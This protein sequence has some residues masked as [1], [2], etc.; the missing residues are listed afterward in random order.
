MVCQPAAANAGPNGMMRSLGIKPVRT[1]VTTPSVI[2][3]EH[4]VN[5][6]EIIGMR[7]END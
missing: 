2:C 1:Y 5:R 3:V 7:V 4:E 6:Y